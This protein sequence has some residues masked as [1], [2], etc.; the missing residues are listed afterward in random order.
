[1][2][3]GVDDPMTSKLPK[4]VDNAARRTWDKEAAEKKAKERELR[5]L[6]EEVLG[7]TKRKYTLEELRAMKPAKARETE[8]D[9]FSGVG[10]TVVIA[11]TTP[12]N[13]RGGFFCEV[14][15]CTIKDSQNYLDHI[16][17]KKHQRAMGSS[18]RPERATLDQV[19]ARLSV[20]K[21]QTGIQVDSDADLDARIERQRL[22]DEAFRQQAKD[23]KQAVKDKKKELDRLAEEERLQDLDP[24]MA[25]MGMPMGFGG[26]VKK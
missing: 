13:Q 23:R 4:G 19:R 16:N 26:G 2:S 15:D 7:K 9:V 5:E 17:G 6:E 11:S 1:M 21:V 25:L 3:Y 20:G 12:I 18:L 24:D 22:A 10:R 8:V 14:C